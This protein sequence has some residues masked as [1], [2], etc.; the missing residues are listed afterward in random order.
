M[1][2]VFLVRKAVQCMCT[3]VDTC[4]ALSNI[5][6][7]S[8]FACGVLGSVVYVCV[9]IKNKVTIYELTPKI[10]NKYEKKKVSDF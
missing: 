6:G 2:T 5:A 3:G 9:A 1:Y 4:N 7:A 8:L 10:K